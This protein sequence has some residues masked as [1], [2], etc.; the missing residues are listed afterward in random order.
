MEEAEAAPSTAPTRPAL[1]RS[2]RPRSQVAAPTAPLVDRPE[3]PGHEIDLPPASTGSIIEAHTPAGPVRIS[4]ETVVTGDAADSI[5][6]AYHRNFEPLRT[7]AVLRHVD[8]RAEVMAQL[9]NPRITKIVAWQGAEPVGLAMV[10]N[11]LEDVEEIS[12]P[13]LRERYPDHA[14]RGTIFVGMLVMVSQPLRGLTLFS[15]L[16]TELWQVAAAAGGVLVFDICEFNR[17]TFGTDVL[18]Q[19]IAD[20]FPRSN[21]Q[22]LDRQTWYVAELPEP[23]PEQPRRDR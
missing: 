12:P 7:L 1:R 17:V 16:S 20:N 10:T 5:Y 2:R 23:I 22:I 3:Q 6:D 8:S 11:S 19:R 13:F 21:L 9:A 15:R 4:H 18:T 14:A